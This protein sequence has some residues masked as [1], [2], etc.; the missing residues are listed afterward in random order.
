MTP[1]T[2]TC[3]VSS[4]ATNASAPGAAAGAIQIT[5]VRA[6]NAAAKGPNDAIFKDPQQGGMGLQ[7]QGLTDALHEQLKG[8]KTVLITISDIPDTVG[9]GAA[10]DRPAPIT[11]PPRPRP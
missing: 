4:A 8:G 3:F 10:P 7:L 2:I 9:Q 11:E 6:P 1:I 5:P